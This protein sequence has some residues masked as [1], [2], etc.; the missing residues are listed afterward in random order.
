MRTKFLPDFKFFFSLCSAKPSS[1]FLVNAFGYMQKE[2][3]QECWEFLWCSEGNMRT[4]EADEREEKWGSYNIMPICAIRF[5]F[6]K[7]EFL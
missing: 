6:F 4:L 3:H 1:G 5:F 2:F 7:E